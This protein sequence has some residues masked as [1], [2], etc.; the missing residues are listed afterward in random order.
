MIRLF[1]D[2]EFVVGEK[3]SLPKEEIR[4]WRSVRRGQGEVE[5]F[6]RLG[7]R[8][9]GRME[10]SEFL[11]ESLVPSKHPLLPVTIALAVP[12]PKVLREV[13][14]SLSELGVS[15]LELFLSERSQISQ[16][17]LE[18]LREKAEK[19]SIE[20][21][22]QCERGALLQIETIAWKN[23]L[24]RAE[25]VD[26]QRIFFDEAATSE[27]KKISFDHPHTWMAIGCEGGWTSAERQAFADDG[28]VGVH[29]PCPILKVH[30]ACIAA[31]SGMLWNR[32]SSLGSY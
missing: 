4:Y 31:A 2:S 5:L 10:G 19:W 23:L 14:A 27:L 15:K 30:T 21:A 13:V 6:N 26:T 3:I 1:Y 8:A 24:G 11:I 16:A 25:L 7:S 17:R 29:L 20:A 32:S 12:E 28:V 9:L 18:G 22:R